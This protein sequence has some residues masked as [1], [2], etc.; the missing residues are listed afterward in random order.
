M[1][2]HGLTE[3]CLK[4]ILNGTKLDAPVVVQLLDH[5]VINNNNN[6][7]QAA[8]TKRFRL[9]LNDG[10]NSFT[11]AMIGNQLNDAMERGDF[12]NYSVITISKHVC[13]SQGQPGQQKKVLII[14]DMTLKT[15]GDQV[16]GKLGDPQPLNDLG[17]NPA[18]NAA[19][20]SHPA[21]QAANTGFGAGG[22]RPQGGQNVSGFGN[23]NGG[24]GFGGGGNNQGN[25]NKS[26]GFGSGGFS[27]G[28]GG[29]NNNQSGGFGNNHNNNGPRP[30]TNGSGNKNANNQNFGGGPPSKR[31][32]LGGNNGSAAPN[33]FRP[34]NSGN[35]APNS[36]QNNGGM[37]QQTPSFPNGNAANNTNG[38]SFGGGGFGGSSGFGGGAP[39]ADDMDG[40]G[41][42]ETPKNIFPLGALTPYTN[43]WTVCVQVKSKEPIRTWTNATGGGE[44]FSMWLADASE[45]MKCSAFK[46][47][48]TKW[49]D[50]LQPGKWYYIRGGQLKPPRDARF[51]KGKSLEMTMSGETLIKECTEYMEPPKITFKFVPINELQDQIPNN[52]IDVIGICSVVEPHT[53]FTS[54]LGKQFTKREIELRD[55]S[56]L[57]VRLTLWGAQAESFDEA[58]T[59]AVLAIKGVKVSDFGG[60]TLSAVPGCD[61]VVNPDIPEAHSLRGWFDSA[62]AGTAAQSIS[63]GGGGSGSTPWANLLEVTERVHGTNLDVKGY[64][65]EMKGTIMKVENTDRVDR[66]LYR[67]CPNKIDGDKTCNK[68]IIDIGVGQWRCER[69]GVDHTTFNWRLM[70][71]LEIADFGGCIKF[72]GVFQEQGEALL[73]R[74]AHELGEMS[75]NDM[76]AY[77]AALTALHFQSFIFKLRAR[78]ENFNDE[79]RLKYNVIEVKPLDHVRYQGIMKDGLRALLTE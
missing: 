39:N 38:S 27:G 50:I 70:L 74:K 16:G 68:K 19:P 64:Y 51:S 73:N 58:N 57:S 42:G 53:S 45:E 61:L 59:N 77:Q 25:G 5:R 63:S 20:P 49:F 6:T 41:P 10:R 44:V 54:K 2:E 67:G 4:A 17:N 12:P 60:R 21:P 72:V 32:N 28:F 22:V 26:G 30:Q 24:G 15:P 78:M 52:V 40:F 9:S 46:N 35:F 71:S 76:S 48:V 62:G 55:T 69:C 18:G 7:G 29:G 56:Q 14:L 23:N 31:P 1:T 37:R 11:Y 13:N 75:Q 65:F 34:N 36:G 79:N 3:G 47:E 8:Q 66:I 33:P 43:K